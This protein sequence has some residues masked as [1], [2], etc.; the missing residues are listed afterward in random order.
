M[1]RKVLQAYREGGV[2]GLSRKAYYLYC[3][4]LE[5]YVR[6]AAGLNESVITLNGVEVPVTRSALD[7]RLPFYTPAVPVDSN[8]V[9][10]SAEIDAIRHYVEPGDHVV[11][12]GGGLGVTATVAA[13]EAGEAGTVTVFEP[14][15]TALGVCTRTIEHNDLTRRVRLEH[16]SVGA[17]QNSCFTYGPQEDL[18]RVAYDELPDADVY[19]MDCEG[20]ELPILK[21]MTV[22]P[23][24]I[25]VE[26][27][28]NHDAVVD[29]L[30]AN[31]YTINSVVDDRSEI[32]ADRTHVRAVHRSD[33]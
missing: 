5:A 4:A 23:R 28:A 26:T 31:G 16:A 12:I 21:G 19:E 6:P 9:Y 11:V 29:V 22:R 18:R 14:S 13:R 7:D 30:Q 8:P 3:Y 27:H 10:E 15:T 17:P 2:S 1:I 32:G 24:V 25:L 20:E 33:G